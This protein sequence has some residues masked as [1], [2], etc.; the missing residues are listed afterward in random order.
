MWPSAIPR[1]GLMLSKY[2]NRFALGNGND[3]KRT[4]LTTEKIAVFVPIPIANA[5]TATRVKPGLFTN[6]RTPYLISC[7]SVMTTLPPDLLLPERF[8]GVPSNE[9]AATYKVGE[10]KRV[11]KLT[12]QVLLME[13]V[14]YHKRDNAA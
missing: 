9:N 13:N 8:D 11:Q 5:S 10:A 14:H 1:S 7:K 2:T 12:C 3:R 6:T 4:P